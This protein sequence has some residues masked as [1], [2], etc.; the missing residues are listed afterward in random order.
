MQY[1]ARY[2][3]FKFSNFMSD[4]PNFKCSIMPKEHNWM[5]EVSKKAVVING[6]LKFVN[7]SDEYLKKWR[8]GYWQKQNKRSMALF[9][10]E[11]DPFE[12]NNLAFDENYAR[13]LEK[14][15]QW[16]E[17]EI[18]RPPIAVVGGWNEA[19]VRMLWW[20]GV[21]NHGKQFFWKSGR[22]VPYEICDKENICTTKILP[23]TGWL[24][25]GSIEYDFARFDKLIFNNEDKILNGS[26]HMEI[27]RSK[28]VLERFWLWAKL[29]GN[30]CCPLLK[31]HGKACRL[32]YANDPFRSV[33]YNIARYNYKI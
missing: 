9:D 25:S 12:L 11:N 23:V 8:Y 26:S 31:R 13:T 27:D 2:G 17:A 24:E 10:I 20:I 15:R 19:Y 16:A 29:C 6:T 5:P 30:L 1:M 18:G 22:A 28:R 14:I 21:S 33:N 4:S 7:Y 3:K 32:E